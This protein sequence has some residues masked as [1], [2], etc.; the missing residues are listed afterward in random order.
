[1][2]VGLR[3]YVFYDV[4]ILYELPTW[5]NKRYTLCPKKNAHIFIF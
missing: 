2:Y 3:M 1:M 4:Y 5:H